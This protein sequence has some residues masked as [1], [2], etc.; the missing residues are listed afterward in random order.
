M[1]GFGNCQKSN[2]ARLSV[3]EKTATLQ[4]CRKSLYIQCC[5]LNYRQRKKL[6]FPKVRQTIQYSFFS[7]G[8]INMA[9]HR[10]GLTFGYSEVRK[11]QAIYYLVGGFTPKPPLK[12]VRL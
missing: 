7:D 6:R 9:C 10:V 8:K 3:I 12:G 4:Y 1:N 5:N 2:I 11:W